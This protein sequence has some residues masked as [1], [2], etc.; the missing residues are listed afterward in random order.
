MTAEINRRAILVSAL[1]L[2]LFSCAGEDFGRP[3]MERL[4]PTEY[5]LEQ[6]GMEE[7]WH[8]GIGHKPVRNV[9]ILDGIICVETKDRKMFAIDTKNGLIRWQYQLDFSLEYPPCD[10]ADG[11]FMLIGDRLYALGKEDG[12]VLWHRP[13]DFGPTGPPAANV[14]LVAVPGR[15]TINTVEAVD[16]TLAWHIRLH[17]QTFAAPAAFGDFFFAGDDSGWVYGINARLGEKMWQRETRGPIE[18]SPFP[19][20]DIVYV[21]S[22][23]Y[24]IYALDPATGFA[25]WESSTGSMIRSKPLGTADAVYVLSYN[26]GVTAHNADSGA[27]KWCRKEANGV[28]AVGAKRAYLLGKPG[29]VLAINA[30]TGELEKRISA[31]QYKFL[32][33]NY[34]TDHLIFVS[35]LGMVVAIREKGVKNP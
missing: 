16:G 17:G 19:M 26:N 32:P 21:G 7:A 8:C 9:Y 22:N 14:G 29:V 5:A 24:K 12:H 35:D 3:Q 10:N 2:C 15:Y 25:K 1:A 4:L 33:T 28:L 23:D 27:Q 34:Y 20:A 6:L 30:Q 31:K 11:V 13:L 18:A